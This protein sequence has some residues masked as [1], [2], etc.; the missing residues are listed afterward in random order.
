MN[1]CIDIGNSRTKIAVFDAT[2]VLQHRSIINGIITPAEIEAYLQQFPVQYGIVSSVAQP[3]PALAAWVAQQPNFIFFTPTTPLPLTHRYATPETLGR[4]RMALAVASHYLFPQRNVLAIDGG[5]CLTYNFTDA[6]ACFWGGAIAPGVNMRY[7]ALHHFTAR[8][9]LV[10]ID[11]PPPADFI[12][13]ST[14]HAIQS[15]VLY[16]TTAEIEQTV[17]RYRRR[18]GECQVLLT[19]G[20]APLLASLLK[21]PLFLQ[22][23][24]VL[25][26]LHK[27]L[28]YHYTPIDKP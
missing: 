24:A 22:P 12:G 5:T 26:G 25:F 20:S 18:F 28:Q 15:G 11:A 1:I 14:Q 3:T 4:D 10:A 2:D 16:G 13:N 19:G 21:I 23:N 6:A 9:P 27:I 7:K 17:H 8:L